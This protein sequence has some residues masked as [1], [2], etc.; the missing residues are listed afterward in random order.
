MAYAGNCK[1]QKT[2]SISNCTGALVSIQRTRCTPVA[3]LRQVKR[4]SKILT[5]CSEPKM[6]VVK[7]NCF[8]CFHV[9]RQVLDSPFYWNVSLIS[10]EQPLAEQ[11]LECSFSVSWH[12][13]KANLCPNWADTTREIHGFRSFPEVAIVCAVF[14]FST[15][16]GWWNHVGRG[17]HLAK[18]RFSCLLVE[19]E[20]SPSKTYSPG[21]CLLLVFAN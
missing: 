16:T 2:D 5:R 4:G 1:S 6:L 7:R 18:Y 14:Q 17:S 19:H 9:F 20:G 3:K 8:L 13:H 10:S 12:V 11:E 21:K 15:L